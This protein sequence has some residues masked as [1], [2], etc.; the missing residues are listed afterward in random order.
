MQLR[1]WLY[2]HRWFWFPFLMF[3]GF[4]LIA[5]YTTA[6]GHW[7]WWFNARRSP[8]SDFF[9][10]VI[11]QF[12]EEWAF[13]VV[14]MVL[15]FQRY[16]SA[17][18]VGLLAII[19]T[20]VAAITKQIFRHPRPLAYFRTLG[21][22]DQLVLV[23]GVQVNASQISSFPSGHTMAGFALF[24]F[25]AFCWSARRHGLDFICLL[26]AISIGLS[27]IY[28]VQHF[29]K[30]VILG[31]LLGVCIG[32]GVYWLHQLP[33]RHRPQSWMDRSLKVLP[34]RKSKTSAQRH[35]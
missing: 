24:S 28:L 1:E 7:I 20:L 11:T 15:L 3:L 18:G 4:C 35:T 10:S 9:F 27:R 29:L 19:V 14:T 13:I 2:S 25:L 23:E 34:L 6:Q 33:Q 22:D 5:L 8:W 12:G 32:A 30:D 26:L 21:L 31:S 16:R 17:L